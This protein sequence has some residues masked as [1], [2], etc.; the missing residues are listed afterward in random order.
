M[1]DLS[2][3]KKLKAKLDKM[4]NKDIK[5]AIRKGTRAGCKILQLEAKEKAPKKTGQLKR[6]IRVRA[7]PRSRKRF[8]TQVK[9][10]NVP[11]AGPLE[12]GTK[13]LEALEF[14]HKATEQ[15]KDK[16][17]QEAAQIIKTEILQAAK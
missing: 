16:A 7:L 6:N 9:L 15:S 2:G 10:T 3:D 12:Y 5:A 17:G 4:A 8:G 14:M 1:I 13:K 11:Y